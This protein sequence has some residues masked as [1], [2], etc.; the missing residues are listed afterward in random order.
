LI[1]HFG[2][3]AF[4]DRGGSEALVPQLLASDE[5]PETVHSCNSGYGFNASHPLP[6]RGGFSAA[7]THSSF[8]TNLEGTSVSGGVNLVTANAGIQPTDKLHLALGTNY[9][10]SLSGQIEES[11]VQAGGIAPETNSNSGSHSIDVIGTAGYAITKTLQAEIDIERRQQSFLGETFSSTGYS[12]SL[13]YTRGLLGGNLNAG[14]TVRDG[15]IANSGQNSVGFS[16]NGNYTRRINDW[17]ATGS[18]GYAQNVQ[19]LLITYMNSFYNYSGNIRHRWGLFT[20]SAGAGAG[21]TGLTQQGATQNTNQ[22]YTTSFG[23]S[24]FITLTGSY[25]KSSG[26]GIETATGIAQNPVLVPV[27]T[28]GYTIVF[29]GNTYSVGLGSNP[30]RKFTI[31]AAYARANNNNLFNS[32]ATSG[33]T[34]EYNTIL[35]YQ[36]RKVYMTGG[37]SRLQQGFSTSTTAPGILSSFYVGLSRWFNFF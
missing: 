35:Q 9:S 25:S 32:V 17:V 22:S 20:W 19:T 26:N 15:T 21:R 10:S 16:F 2:L 11:I 30:A 4:Y 28:P 18:F 29:S 34:I 24:R 12:G 6:M 7:I 31:G 23:Y 3:G 8:D 27:L 37:Y 5:P 13:F 14:A 36:F 1:D 33:S